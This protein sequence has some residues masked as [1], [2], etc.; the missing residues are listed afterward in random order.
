VKSPRQSLSRAFLRVGFYGRVK[1]SS[2]KKCKKNAPKGAEIFTLTKG[3][4]KLLKG[5]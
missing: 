3:A 1:K 5:E 4:V 2:K